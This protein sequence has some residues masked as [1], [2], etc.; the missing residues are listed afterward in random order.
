[1]PPKTQKKPT[2]AKAKAKAKAKTNTKTKPKPKPKTST[3]NK[4]NSNQLNSLS[5]TAAHTLAGGFGWSFGS[6]AGSGM[7]NSIFD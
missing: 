6:R 7:F 2:K 3:T 5:Q 4:K 1:M